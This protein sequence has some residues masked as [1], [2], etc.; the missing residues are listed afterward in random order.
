MPHCVNEFKQTSDANNSVPIT[1]YSF[2]INFERQLNLHLNFGR[3]EFKLSLFSNA[4]LTL[5]FA[6][7]LFREYKGNSYL[8][9]AKI[10]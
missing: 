10:S 9:L 7:V 2:N 8:V 4:L 3:K 1:L 5:S 6:F